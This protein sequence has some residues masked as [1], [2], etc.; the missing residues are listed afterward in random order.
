MVIKTLMMQDLGFLALVARD[1]NIRV[2]V[3]VPPPTKVLL[4]SFCCPYVVL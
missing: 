3:D 1:E 2:N 4:S